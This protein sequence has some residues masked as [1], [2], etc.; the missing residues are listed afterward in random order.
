MSIRVSGYIEPWEFSQVDSCL[1]VST[2]VSR[3]FGK[4][5]LNSLSCESRAHT[6]QKRVSEQ[7][8]ETFRSLRSVLGN[9]AL[10][11]GEF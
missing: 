10:G 5:S 6:Q 11:G 1:S 4:S 2:Y 3:H 9:T 7:E 8:T